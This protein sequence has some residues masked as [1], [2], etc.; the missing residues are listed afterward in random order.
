[1][2]GQAISYL[3]LLTYLRNMADKG[4]TVTIEDVA[5]RFALDYDDTRHV[6]LELSALEM[7]SG[8]DGYTFELDFGQHDIEDDDEEAPI[9]PVEKIPLDTEILFIPSSSTPFGSLH[10]TLAEVVSLLLLIDDVLELT[11][12]G[13]DHENLKTVRELLTSAAAN[14]GYPNLLWR[15]DDL[16]I[17]HESLATLTEAIEE[18]CFVELS[19]SHLDIQALPRKMCEK[20]TVREV[21]PIRFEGGARPVL[22]TVYREGEE[23]KVRTYRIDR[24]GT[25]RKL[26]TAQ[27]Y[28]SALKTVRLD[29]KKNEKEPS[30]RLEGGTNVTL[31]ITRRAMWVTEQFPEGNWHQVD[32][33][34]EGTLNVRSY[35]FLFPLLLQIGT[36]LVTLEPAE[37][38]ETVAAAFTAVAKDYT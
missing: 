18:K 7:A 12:P 4:H 35:D 8:H 2:S 30:F 37:V 3:S 26:Q 27:Q 23:W 6:L 15:A 32:D 29:A 25:V 31:R 10:L 21:L 36:D 9:V 1:M 38:R 16:L 28:P 24:I 13:E 22:K 14:K 34:L 19:Y 11:P 33:G 20:V 5:D 17:S